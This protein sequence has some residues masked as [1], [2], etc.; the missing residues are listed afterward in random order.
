MDLTIYRSEQLPDNKVYWH[1]ASLPFVVFKREDGWTT[2]GMTYEE[3]I[4]LAK[5]FRSYL[6]SQENVIVPWEGKLRSDYCGSYL[7]SASGEPPVILVRNFKKDRTPRGVENF[8]KAIRDGKIVVNDYDSDLTVT[9]KAQGKNE[10]LTRSPYS[11]VYSW[12]AVMLHTQPD[13]QGT[14]KDV[15]VWRGMFLTDFRF[16]S[17]YNKHTE[18]TT[19]NFGNY[20]IDKHVSACVK[21]ISE[22]KVVEATVVTAL[23]KANQGQFDILSNLA[24]LPETVMGI[25]SGIREIFRMYKEARKGDF[26]LQNKIS[27]LRRIANPTL[28]QRKQLADALEASASVWLSYRLS[29]SPTVGVVEDLIDLYFRGLVDFERYR[30]TKRDNVVDLSYNTDGSTTIPVV[31]RAFIKRK[32]DLTISKFGFPPL[33]AVWELVPLSFVLDRYVNI[34][35]LLSAFS[36]DLSVEQGAT[37]SWKVTGSASG[38]YNDLVDYQVTV[39][40]YKRR[41]INPYHYCGLNFPPSRTFEQDLDHLSLFWSIVMD[42]Y[43][44]PSKS[45]KY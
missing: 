12:P 17:S 33:G 14:G 11:S 4:E 30:E 25:L 6:K 21:Q 29:I 34:G 41:V 31:E 28:N 32:Y 19:S 24:E 7:Q 39:S 13:P 43:V 38:N 20:D 18:R 22:L 3:S 36:P 2:R 45:R 42:D 8:S 35:E 9:I 15:Y 16:R 5:D 23:A 10:I 1:F 37:Y 40:H 27:R 44:R 26:R